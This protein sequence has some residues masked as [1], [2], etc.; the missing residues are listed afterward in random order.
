MSILCNDPHGRGVETTGLLPPITYDHPVHAN[1]RRLLD[2]DQLD[3]R[4]VTEV[5]TEEHG[6]LAVGL[7]PDGSPFAV[8][9]LCRHQFAKLGRGRVTDDGCL[10]CPPWHRAD[11]DVSDGGAMTSGPRGGRIFGFKPYSWAIKTFGNVAR[12]RTFVVELKDGVIWLL[13]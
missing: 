9:N 11:Y 4:R 10:Q 8:R 13:E 3:D 6:V 1:G 7:T 5:Q 12:L 2:V